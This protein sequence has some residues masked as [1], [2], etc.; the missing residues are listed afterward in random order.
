MTLA[1]DQRILNDLVGRHAVHEGVL[2]HADEKVRVAEPANTLVHVRNRSEADLCVERI[3]ETRD[4][5]ASS[6]TASASS[7]ADS[8]DRTHLDSIGC[9]CE[10]AET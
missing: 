9:C 3:D 1:A 8:T 7:A 5:P 6:S 10:I 4:E 2:A